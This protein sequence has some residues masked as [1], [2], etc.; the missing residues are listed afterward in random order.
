MFPFAGTRTRRFHRPAWAVKVVCLYAVVLQAA[1]ST[2]TG[3]TKQKSGCAYEN[4][5]AGGLRSMIVKCLKH[6]HV[7]W[8][9]LSTMNGRGNG[10]TLDGSVG[11]CKFAKS[12]T[13]SVAL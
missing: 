1:V 9:G 2:L 10:D 5:L 11:D 13:F 3:M 7:S 6:I 8:P 12:S 4:K